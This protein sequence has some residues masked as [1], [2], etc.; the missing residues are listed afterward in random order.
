MCKRN[1]NTAKTNIN[2]KKKELT[3]LAKPRFTSKPQ[4]SKNRRLDTGSCP[5]DTGRVRRWMLCR[6]KDNCKR[7]NWQSTRGRAKPTRGVVNSKIF[8]ISDST[9]R[10]LATGLAVDTRGR[11]S[12]RS[13]KQLMR[14]KERNDHGVVP[15]GHR[16]WWSF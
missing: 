12:T 15:G 8:I 9:A 2:V 4:N 7:Q 16:P 5:P 14:K 1:K 11:V 6:R 3:Q 10:T 13:D